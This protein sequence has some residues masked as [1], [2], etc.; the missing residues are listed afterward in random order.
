LR[1]AFIE[2]QSQAG[3]SSAGA[4]H[5][6]R[7]QRIEQIQARFFNLVRNL[8]VN[9]PGTPVDHLFA[10]VVAAL[11]TDKVPEGVLT[12]IQQ[13]I[14]A[15]MAHPEPR[16]PGD[17]APQSPYRGPAPPPKF[18]EKDMRD[19]SAQP[20]RLSGS[21]YDDVINLHQQN[22]KPNDILEALR[23]QG[24]KISVQSIGRIIQSLG[25]PPREGAFTP[26]TRRLTEDGAQQIRDYSAAD[27]EIHSLAYAFGV[28]VGTVNKVIAGNFPVTRRSL[29]E[30]ARATI[31][32]YLQ[33]NPGA[34]AEEIERETS[35]SLHLVSKHLAYRKLGAPPD[36]ALG[37]DDQL[38]RSGI[39]WVQS[40]KNRGAS[41][42][43]IAL[44][45]TER[46]PKTYETILD[47]VKNAPNN[48]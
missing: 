5:G 34:S 23:T 41:I 43:D 42:T 35:V 15:V 28:G 10:Q 12:L 45:L 25:Y 17:P 48:P 16:Q 26:V 31:E 36:D 40:K 39:A 11:R 6:T 19:A 18:T 2:R 38:T 14:D 33:R 44:V 3:G 37:A 27:G 47:I 22:K 30:I 20:A 21:L 8:S 9:N 4:A 32:G 24:K 13:A 46:F 1:E 7:I 29:T